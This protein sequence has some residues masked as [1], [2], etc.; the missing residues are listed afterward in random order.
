MYSFVTALIMFLV[1]G[2]LTVQ[3]MVEFATIQ[4]IFV[5]SVLVL[6]FVL[7]RFGHQIVALHEEYECMNLSH[8]G[9][10]SYSS[11]YVLA[12]SQIAF[13]QV[14]AQFN[15]LLLDVGRR[16][17]LVLQPILS[18]LVA[19][20][21]PYALC[22]SYFSKRAITG[23]IC[24]SYLTAHLAKLGLLHVLD[25][26]AGPFRLVRAA[27]AP[28]CLFVYMMIAC[29][30]VY[31]F[32][33][34]FLRTHAVQHL[35]SI[36]D[37][38]YGL[39]MINP[40]ELFILDIDKGENLNY[41][42][43]EPPA[44]LPQYKP[45][46]FA[47]SAKPLIERTNYG[48]QPNS[49]A[50]MNGFRPRDSMPMPVESTCLPQSNPN[51]LKNEA[52]VAK[53]SVFSYSRRNCERVSSPVVSQ[54]AVVPHPLVSYRIDQAPITPAPLKPHPS[55][56]AHRFPSDLRP[57]CIYQQIKP[58]CG[59][60]SEIP[61]SFDSPLVNEDEISLSVASPASSED[62]LPELLHDSAASND[63]TDI[64]TSSDDEA[65]PAFP[66]VVEY[67][68]NKNNHATPYGLPASFVPF[69]ALAS[70]V[71]AKTSPM[72]APKSITDPAFKPKDEKPAA[73]LMRSMWKL[74]AKRKTKLQGQKTQASVEIQS[75]P[76]TPSPA[77]SSA[78]PTLP[79]CVLTSS[80]S[81]SHDPLKSVLPLNL[82]ATDT[83]TTSPTD[84]T[85]FDRYNHFHSSTS[86]TGES[87]L[88]DEVPV[89]SPA[90]SP[91][92]SQTSSWAPPT[93]CNVATSDTM[94][95]SKHD[96]I[97]SPLHHAPTQPP[98]QIKSSPPSL[99]QA[100]TE[101]LFA[102]GR[103]SAFSGLAA[104]VSMTPKE[105][106]AAMS[107]HISNKPT[108]PRANQPAPVYT[109]MDIARTVVP[110]GGMIPPKTQYQVKDG[111]G[112]SLRMSGPKG[113]R[114]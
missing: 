32:R 48:I 41:C 21:R 37:A 12:L 74:K 80:I 96:Q 28:Q 18:P 67:G 1:T 83:A 38:I 98:Q 53:R 66:A 31:I 68:A 76:S 106:A 82:A 91:A 108:T 42:P 89:L 16:L 59:T 60:T 35:E 29:A 87:S 47:F 100:P 46:S 50:W 22:L 11:S 70:S 9:I 19:I 97:T 25:G 27:L 62:S 15:A 75:F 2:L 8:P 110:K 78:S 26:M 40:S 7:F 69:R 73:I 34:S 14:I 17:D 20:L 5:S 13:E 77:S 49:P 55:L 57:N 61:Q 64:Q 81:Q 44:N 104:P 88:N 65:S 4:P 109:L 72:Y 52:K 33:E 85:L 113:L 102:P 39:R 54:L 63:S 105:L 45:P 84:T 92:S 93:D 95:Q 51:I 58:S 43:S 23:L 114:V 36:L 101:V 79:P 3:D 107:Q 99:S 90:V 94:P 103:A 6:A 112:T 24:A 56:A 30:F 10:K 86:S 111:R 71:Q